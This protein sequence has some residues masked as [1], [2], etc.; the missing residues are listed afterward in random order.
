MVA[1]N[2]QLMAAILV[3][4]SAAVVPVTA[5]AALDTTD[6][7]IISLYRLDEHTSGHIDNLVGNSF[8]DTASSGTPQ[9]NDTFNDD[10]S[11]G[12][13]WTS[14]AAFTSGA[15]V[16]GDGIGLDFSLADNDRT[17]FGH[18]LDTT[19]RNYSNGKSFTIMLRI[20]PGT[21]L[22]NTF[23]GL[24]G[25]GSEG[26]TL[27]GVSGGGK[28]RMDVEVRDGGVGGDST[29]TYWTLNSYAG[30]GTGTEFL[31]YP[32]KWANVFLIYDADNTLTIAMDD[33]TTF[34]S[35]SSTTVPT[36]FSSLAEGFADADYD[37]VLG[38]RTTDEGGSYDG[39][40][41]SAVIW[42]RALTNTEA[43]AIGLTNVPEPGGAAVVGLLLCALGG[44][45][46]R[47]SNPV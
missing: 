15:T 10:P 34:A 14:G 43:M 7:S 19:Q 29:Q 38:S 12:P 5:S 46:L 11:S 21:L 32:D 47:R 27:E 33:G 39:L 28:A 36:G 2:M 26:I 13:T 20:K 41:E 25:V 37:W 3:A 35:M 31:L 18:W 1:R 44:M 17:R 40:I 42:D 24:L 4:T 22:D 6:P 30:T 23:Y 45:R 8:L 9:N 16:V